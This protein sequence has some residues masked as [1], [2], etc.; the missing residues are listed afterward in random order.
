MKMIEDSGR[1]KDGED[2]CHTFD[3]SIRAF[4]LDNRAPSPI[5]GAGGKGET[6]R[7]LVRVRWE[8][9]RLSDEI[10][11]S[12]E[13]VIANLEFDGDMH[14]AWKVLKSSPVGS[15]APKHTSAGGSSKIKPP[16]VMPQDK[17]I[18]DED[19]STVILKF[20]PGALPRGWCFDLNL[21]PMGLF[22]SEQ[23]LM[24]NHTDI[25]VSNCLCDP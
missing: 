12:R 21:M 16:V 2:L 8:G 1:L 22:D 7:R 9:T 19:S 20:A 13:H 25:C 17:M 10:Y 4:R 24:H 14:T 3:L 11:D 18:D 6:M 23:S 15:L 5:G